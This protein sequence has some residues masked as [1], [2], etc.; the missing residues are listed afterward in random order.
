M[1]I[2]RFLIIFG[3]SLVLDALILPF[4][5]FGFTS[6]PRDTQVLAFMAVCLLS[7][8]LFD[9]TLSRNNDPWDKA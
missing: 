3:L 1:Q 4:V 2:H 5:F 6:W 8:L 9:T 7:Y